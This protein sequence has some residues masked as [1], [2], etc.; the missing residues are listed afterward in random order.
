MLKHH[1]ILEK[2]YH[3]HHNSYYHLTSVL[4]HIRQQ[5]LFDRPF[6]K[7]Q[8]KVPYDGHCRSWEDVQSYCTAAPRPT[9][10]EMITSNY[11]WLQMECRNYSQP[12]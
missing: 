12:Q 6:Q 7:L 2:G 4:L 8:I 5:G 9:L 10:I 1:I 3:T 11:L